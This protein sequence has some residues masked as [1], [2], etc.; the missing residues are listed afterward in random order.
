MIGL[1][2]VWQSCLAGLCVSPWLQSGYTD[3]SPKRLTSSNLAMLAD[4]AIC[5]RPGQL[6]CPTDKSV[7]SSCSDLWTIRVP[8]VETHAPLQFPSQGSPFLDVGWHSHE[9]LRNCLQGQL[10]L[11]QRISCLPSL[12]PDWMILS[13]K[14]VT[15]GCVLRVQLQLLWGHKGLSWVKLY[16]PLN[17]WGRHG[18]GSTGRHLDTDH[19]TSRSQHLQ[20]VMRRKSERAHTEAQTVQCT[21]CRD[22]SS[23]INNVFL[24]YQC[25]PEHASMLMMCMLWFSFISTRVHAS[26]LMMCMLWFS[27]I[28]TQVY[29]I[30]TR[31][32]QAQMVRRSFAMTLSAATPVIARKAEVVKHL[33][34]FKSSPLGEGH[35]PMTRCASS[36]YLDPCIKDHLEV[37]IHRMY[38]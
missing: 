1:A 36:L 20:A 27:C 10:Q 17:I 12:E 24:L 26:M 30:S 16:L 11:L 25:Q 21:C 18:T 38:C 33:E 35:W 2:F 4:S 28:S 22:I 34:S 9:A 7:L 23:F 19:T 37:A 6:A 13:K 8:R 31:I 15:S 14:R 5:H 29:W 3:A 32:S